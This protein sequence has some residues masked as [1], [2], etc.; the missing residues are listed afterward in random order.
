MIAKTGTAFSAA[1]N[2][3]APYLALVACPRV[4]PLSL[5]VQPA[6]RYATLDLPCFLLGILK[7]LGNM[8]IPS[9]LLKSETIWVILSTITS[10]GVVLEIGAEHLA[11]K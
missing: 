1:S 7:E 6:F 4:K 10:P 8:R 3:R 9:A 2:R 11:E 5:F